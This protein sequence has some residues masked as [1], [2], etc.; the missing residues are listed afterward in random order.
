MKNPSGFNLYQRLNN[1]LLIL[2]EDAINVPPIPTSLGQFSSLVLTYAS[3]TPSLSLAFNVSAGDDAGYKLYAT[4]PVSAGVDFVKS[5]YRL[6]KVS[7]TNP[8]S[9]LNILT[10]YTTKFGAV[11]GIGTKIFVKLIPTGSVSGIEAT[12]STVSA[13]AAT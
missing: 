2:G 5:E 11:G 3:G 6:I 9:P 4:P 7:G 13:I 12:A 1:N 8:T 10:D